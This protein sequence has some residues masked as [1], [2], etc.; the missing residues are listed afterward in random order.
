M[1]PRRAFKAKNCL[2]F[3]VRRPRNDGQLDL[4]C[5]NMTFLKDRIG[6]DFEATTIFGMRSIVHQWCNQSIA[7]RT[8]TLSSGIRRWSPW[9]RGRSY[10]CGRWTGVSR[11]SPSSRGFFG[12]TA[13]VTRWRIVLGSCRLRLLLWG[14]GILWG[15]WRGWGRRL[16]WFVGE[17]VVFKVLTHTQSLFW[18]IH[19]TVPDQ[20]HK[21]FIFFTAMPET[22]K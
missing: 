10:R 4:F 3:F 12:A 15:L 13:A 2:S 22:S 6:T 21:K 19:Q 1:N 18:V 8:N 7:I 5:G 17:V 14:G 16:F 20:L 9:T 11:S